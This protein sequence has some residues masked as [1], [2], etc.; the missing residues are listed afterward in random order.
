MSTEHRSEADDLSPAEWRQIVDSA[1]DT[2]IISTDRQGRVTSWNEGAHRILG[3]TEAEMIGQSPRPPL[4][5][6][7]PSASAA[8]QGNAATRWRM[9]AAAARKAGASARTAAVSG[10][11]GAITPIRGEDAACTRLRQGPARPHRSAARRGRSSREE[12]RALEILNRAGSALAGETDLHSWCRSSPTPASSSP[13]P[14]SARSSTMCSN[15]GRRELHALHAVGR[16]ARSLLQVPDA[17][18]HRGLRADLQ[19]R[20][21]RAVR[22]HHP[23]PALRPQRAAQG[24]AGGPSAGA[25]LSRRAGHLAH[26]RGHRRAVLRPRRA[27]VFTE[28]SERGLAGLGGRGGRGASTTS[29]LA[30]GRAARDRRAPARRRG[31]AEL[32]ATLEQQVAERTEQAARATRRR[33]RQ[34]QKM[35]AVGQLTG[36]VAHD[37]N[38]LLQVIIG[39]LDTLQRHLPDEIRRACRRAASQRDE[40]AQARRGADPAPARLFAPPAARSEAARTSTP[41]HRHV[42][43]AAPHAGRDRSR[44]RRCWRRA[45]GRSRPTPNEL[46]SGDPQPRGQRARRHAGRRQAHDRDRQR[47]HRRG[48]CRQRMPR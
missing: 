27:G 17:A 32:N 33:L 34:S 20:R 10:R 15:D 28:R 42:R 40:R 39:N 7:R 5:R 35:E 31:A 14:S 11:P 1:I 21:H 48:L 23:G 16:A 46:E 9:G 18:Q 25:Q 26:R 13:A 41:G 47:P 38:N 6:G 37:F 30:A 12:R 29:R 4:P 24:H 44:S 8:C 19:R 22:R 3:W 2:A 45:S 36:G 43:P